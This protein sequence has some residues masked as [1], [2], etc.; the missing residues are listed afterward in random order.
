[1]NTIPYVGVDVSKPTLDLFVPTKSLSLSFPNDIAGF[2]KIRKKFKKLKMNSC[3]FVMEASGGYE[4]AAFDHL[5]E[6]GFEVSI[7]N[8]K[9]VRDFARA[10]GILAKTDQIDAQVLASFAEAFQPRITEPKSTD[11]KSLAS[12]VSRRRTIVK[13]INA[14]KNRL[15][16]TSSAEISGMIEEH[17]QFLKGSLKRLN[18]TIQRLLK[19]STELSQKSEVLQSIPGIGE[20]TTALL[21]GELPELG[22]LTGREISAL[23]G[24]APFNK[25]SG[26]FQGRRRIWGGR[27]E[28]RSGLFMA[29][30]VASRKNE[31]LKSFYSRLRERGKSHK[32]ALTAVIRKLIVISNAMI[33]HSE[34]WN[35]KKYASVT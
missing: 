12:L 10:K 16:Q 13:T 3:R 19:S 1:M 18:K 5:S 35:E 25:D 34:C 32:L 31:V 23:V 30:F 14:E 27:K 6:A 7:V 33:K 20:T 24:V 29:A 26:S 2:K 21:L 11:Q 8:P 22:E 9:R 28:V 15:L 17:L 4:Q